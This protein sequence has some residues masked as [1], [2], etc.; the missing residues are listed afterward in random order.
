MHDVTWCSAQSPALQIEAA[1]PLQ[2]E[3]PTNGPGI[4]MMDLARQR[5]H[6]AES[7]LCYGVS[8]YVG[9]LLTRMPRSW[10]AA[11]SMW[12]YPVDRVATKRNLG[13]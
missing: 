13:S 5:K 12:S 9:T 11:R 6:E 7:V 4:G 3:V 2:A 1:Q 10:H 8:P